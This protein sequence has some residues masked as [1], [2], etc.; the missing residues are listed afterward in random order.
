MKQ[1]DAAPAPARFP[2]V[3]WRFTR[4]ERFWSIRLEGSV[5]LDADT[6]VFRTE[7]ESKR[8]RSAVKS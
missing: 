8:S 2:S 4:A 1:I 6:P 3:G 5:L 7:L